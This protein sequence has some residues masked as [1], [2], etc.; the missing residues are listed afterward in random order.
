MNTV[1]HDAIEA[2]ARDYI[3]GWFEG[4]ASRM[5]RALS[6]D[7]RKCTIIREPK[8]GNMTVGQPNNNAFRMVKMTEL[9][10]MKEDN[11][12]I[13]VEVLFVFRDIAAA[14]TTCPYFDDLLHL[15]NYGKYG[16]RIFGKLQKENGN[17][18]WRKTWS[19]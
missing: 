18:R 10:I 2:T 14:R 8:S 11:V 6:P 1:D 19:I 13:D 5:A 15:A 17:H 7:L 9:G 16:W 12:P 4:D 3:E